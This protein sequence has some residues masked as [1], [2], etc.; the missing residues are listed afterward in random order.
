MGAAE[1]V[2]E[3]AKSK[4][5]NR[6]FETLK[7]KLQ[8]ENNIKYYEGDTEYL[9]EKAYPW[10]QCMK[11]Q[12]AEYGS[13]EEAKKVCGAIKAA[14]S[15][16]L[17]EGKRGLS[18]GYFKKEHGIGKDK[19]DESDDWIQHAIKRPGALHRELGV[20]EDEDI[21][22]WKMDD[23]ED[24]LEAEKRRDHRAGRDMS[25]ADRREL[26]QIDLAKT[27]EKFTENKA[28]KKKSV[29]EN[30]RRKRKNVRRK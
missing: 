7:K 30:L 17:E 6:I 15:E 19:I 4:L 25:A 22:K 14:Y 3:S 24:R 28:S 9:A 8:K 10:D 27:L 20:P 5:T 12:E 11:D 23:A 2:N 29:N 21:P 16:G 26:R 1:E 18:K 13:E